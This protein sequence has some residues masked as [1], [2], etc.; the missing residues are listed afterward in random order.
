MLIGNRTDVTPFFTR[1]TPS[2]TDSG[3]RRPMVTRR[4]RQKTRRFKAK[5]LHD[6][7]RYRSVRFG[8][9]FEHLQNAYDAMR[10]VRQI[11]DSDAF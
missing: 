11:S 7:V 1:G 8:C 9:D 4:P 6:I 2:A 10:F 3:R 5:S